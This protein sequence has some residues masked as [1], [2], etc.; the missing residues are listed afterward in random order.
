MNIANIPDT[1]NV[2]AS[3]QFM[4]QSLFTKPFI[5]DTD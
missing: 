4:D 2:Q 1:G 5:L 3:A